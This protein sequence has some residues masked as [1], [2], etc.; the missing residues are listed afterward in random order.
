MDASTEEEMQSTT[1][2]FYCHKCNNGATDEPCVCNG[3]DRV[4]V[5]VD[6]DDKERVRRERR[7]LQEQI[8]RLRRNRERQEARKLGSRLYKA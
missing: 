5:V 4:I 8:R 6:Q 7:R 2:E 1:E 3:S